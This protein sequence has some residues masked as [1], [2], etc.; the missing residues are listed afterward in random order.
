M[1]QLNHALSFQPV[2]VLLAL[3]ACPLLEEFIRFFGNL[4]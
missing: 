3:S 4:G 1:L 2:L